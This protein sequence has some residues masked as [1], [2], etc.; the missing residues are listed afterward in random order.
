MAFLDSCVAKIGEAIRA[1]GMGEKATVIVVSDH[2]FRP[3]TK[4][5][6]PAVTLAGAGLGEKVY[7][8]PEGGTAL[9]YFEDLGL[10]QKVRELFGKAEG[11]ARVIGK[12]EFAGLGVPDPDKDKQ[13]ARLVLAAKPGYSF[14]GGRTGGAVV[15]GAQRGAHGFL[16]EDKEMD[17]IFLA[18]G[19]GVK[20]GAVVER[21]RNVDVA[22]TVAE[23]L[24]VKVEGMEGRSLTEILR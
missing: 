10:E 18:V 20:A 4:V 11:V 15:E 23:L 3:Y 19:Y 1:A 21:V 24:G 16:A 7:A 8:L 2:G 14:G 9:V 13:M 17:G 6:Q 22:A 5:I 12:E